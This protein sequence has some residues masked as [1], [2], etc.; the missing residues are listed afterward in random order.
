[1][2]GWLAILR[3]FSTVFKSYQDDGRL[4]LKGCVQWSSVL[5]LR[6]FRLE[7][8]VALSK[9]LCGLFNTSMS[10]S[11]FPDIWKEANV[12]PLHKKVIPL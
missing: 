2:D 8:S 6:R 12:S 4:I 11:H 10:K 5:R 7:L 3:P 1:M 9:P